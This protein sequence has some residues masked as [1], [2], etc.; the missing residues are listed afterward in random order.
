MAN[1]EVFIPAK[2][3]TD[4]ESVFVEVE[5]SSWLLALRSGMQKVGEQGDSLASVM[6]ENHPDGTIVVKDPSSRRMFRIKQIN[7]D[8]SEADCCKAEKKQQEEDAEAA[9]LREEALAA[10]K[11]EIEAKKRYEETLAKQKEAEERAR[12]EREE[13]IK[14]EQEAEKRKI[15]QEAAKAAVQ[16]SIERANAQREFVEKEKKSKEAKRKAAE[17]A[18][19]T[20]TEIKVTRT[21]MSLDEVNAN[22]GETADVAEV[23]DVEGILADLFMETMDVLSMNKD[24]AINFVLDLAM[25]KI[26]AEAGSVILSDINSILSDLYFAAARGRVA[27]ELSDL[28]IPRGKGIV[29]FSVS[30]GCTLAVS[31]ANQ[32]PNYYKNVSEKTG[33]DSRSILCVPIQGGER[34]F[35]AIEIVNKNGSNQWTPGEVSIVKFLADKLGERL[36]IHHDNVR[37]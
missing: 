2:P 16:A 6:C 11:A 17:S 13:E 7:G 36:D 33:F 29:G 23:I 10:A 5:A 25:D 14:A 9:R 19:G 8:L 4:G 18:T 1:Y 35:G 22:V 24:D 31:D 34:T 27:S 26:K 32:N 20:S 15:Q 21:E 28:R 12:K 30:A 37:L 3:G